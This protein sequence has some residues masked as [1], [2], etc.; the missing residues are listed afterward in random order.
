[1]LDTELV[2]DRLVLEPFHVRHAALLFPILSDAVLYTYM[3]G[4]APRTLAELEAKYRVW[5]RRRAPDGSELWLNWAARLRDGGYVGWFQATVKAARSAEIAYVIGTDHQRRGY[6]VEGSRAVIEHLV[7]DFGVRS[8][9]AQ[10]DARNK[11][12]IAV[13][14]ALNMTPAVSTVRGDVRFEWHP[15]II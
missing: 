9:A 12:S 13:A 4:E 2:S 15:Q 1:L 11:A 10:A 14:A 3:N 7:R 5:M 8:V 6:A